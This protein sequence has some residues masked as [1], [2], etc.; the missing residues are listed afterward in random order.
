MSQPVKSETP[1]TSDIKVELTPSSS[2]SME[3][4]IEPTQPTEIVVKERMIDHMDDGGF[5]EPFFDRFMIN[6]KGLMNK[7]QHTFQ[8]GR[9]IESIMYFELIDMF[10]RTYGGNLKNVTK[11]HN[12]VL[13][14]IKS[15]RI[16]YQT[17]M[18]I[19][20]DMKHIQELKQKYV[21]FLSDYEKNDDNY[22]QFSREVG[23]DIQRNEIIRML[24]YPLI[25]DDLY[26]YNRSKISFSFMDLNIQAKSI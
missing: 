14:M 15:G 19:K 5:N 8:D 22:K 6:L 12:Y 18:K 16:K 23:F 1:E 10:I 11:L 9:Y 4:D 3:K 24:V 21:R 26:T 13:H 20:T 2:I 17:E 25:I 7:G